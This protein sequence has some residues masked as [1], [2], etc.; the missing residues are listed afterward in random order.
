VL[1]ANPTHNND[2]D[3][4]HPDSDVKSNQSECPFSAH[5]HKTR[6]C[7]DLSNNNVIERA[8]RVGISYGPEVSSNE[9]MSNATATDLGLAFGECLRSHLVYEMRYLQFYAFVQAK[10]V[11]KEL[12]TVFL[13][14]D[15][16]SDNRNNLAKTLY[17]LLTW[18]NE[19]INSKLCNLR[20]DYATFIAL[21]NL[22]G[23][24]NMTASEHSSL[25]LHQVR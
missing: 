7:A 23:L 16:A 2:F 15:G 21:F 19:H 12:C 20:D 3:F 10:M 1:G 9:A 6:P 4:S 17:L 25:A 18:L 8:I 11:R 5:I 13:D 22:P 24:Q 14:L